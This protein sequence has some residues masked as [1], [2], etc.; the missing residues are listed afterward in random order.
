[1]DERSLLMIQQLV[2]VLILILTDMVISLL[3]FLPKLA[4]STPQ[5]PIFT[6]PFDR[7]KQFFG[8]EGIITQIDKKLQEHQRVSLSGLG[9]I[10][11]TKS[12]MK[13]SYIDSCGQEVPDRYRIR[14]PLSNDPPSKSCLLGVCC[15]LQPI[16]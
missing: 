11:Y 8:R 3:T 5:K 15:K 6:V 4:L 9:G 10:G 14:L 2:L 12:Y 1:M 16:S 7:D 13:L